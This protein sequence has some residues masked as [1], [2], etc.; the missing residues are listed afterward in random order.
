MCGCVHAQVRVMPNTP[1]LIGQA[2]SAYVLGNNATGQDAAKTYTLMSSAGGGHTMLCACFGF[3][4]VC[5]GW[6]RT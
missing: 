5:T 3:R 6:Q 1:C 4:N 2:A